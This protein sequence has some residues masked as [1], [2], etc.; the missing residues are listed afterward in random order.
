MMYDTI[1][2]YSVE[3]VSDGAETRIVAKSK[4]NPKNIANLNSYFQKNTAGQYEKYEV[5]GSNVDRVLSN[6]IRQGI[7]KGLYIDNNVYEPS[8]SM[9]PNGDITHRQIRHKRTIGEQNYTSTGQKLS[10]HWPIFQKFRDTGFGSIIRAT[11][12][13]HQVCASRCSFC[14]TI[15]RSRKDAISLDEAKKFVIDLD[16]KQR[17]FNEEHFPE[18]NKKYRDLTGSDIKLRGLIL[19]GGGQP[20]LWPHFSAFVEWLSDR[21]IELGLITNGFP[22]HIND[23]I[24]KHF[25]W[26]R[27]SITP[28]DASPF[29]PQQQFDLQRFPGSIQNNAHQTFGMSYVYG[30]WTNDDLLNRLNIAANRWGAKY[31][32]LL[33]DCNLP[34]DLQLTAH[35][36]LGE[37]LF[38]L[39]LVDEQGNPTSKIFHQLKYH[40]C[41]SETLDVWDD[42]QCKLQIYN[43]FWDTTGHEVNG[44]SHCYPC[45]S[46]TV[47]E[48][49]ANNA[50]RR[51]NPEKWGTVTNNEVE[52]LYT[53]PVQ[54][55]FDPNKNCQACLFVN[56]N[57]EVKR[58][59][60]LTNGEFNQI[61]NAPHIEHVNFP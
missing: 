50:E 4:V 7:T 27:L 34:R 48:E 21:D 20:N 33:T 36:D 15:N 19:S 58:L 41:P 10:G 40:S 16:E 32:R 18:Y 57:K 12:T 44:K 42:N 11:M 14:S 5:T 24:Y 43:T 47:L 37:R 9:A 13:L 51:F 49:N 26:I 56:N 1:D 8:T 61:S 28:E 45:D 54:A 35:V 59:T 2:N 25:R 17:H 38:R 6:V 22:K 60:S 23:K 55:F 53:R 46:V 39:G 31:V 52:G 3:V 30:P 29:Y